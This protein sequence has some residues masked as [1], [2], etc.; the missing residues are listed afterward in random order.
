[1]SLLLEE[2]TPRIGAWCDAKLPLE[3]TFKNDTSVGLFVVIKKN[4][5]QYNERERSEGL[6]NFEIKINQNINSL[7]SSGLPVACLK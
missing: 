3:V 6:C 4:V 2:S 1:M 5:I 7:S